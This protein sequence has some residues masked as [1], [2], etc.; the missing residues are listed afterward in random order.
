M[1]TVLSTVAVI[2][3]GMLV[4]RVV[5]REWTRINRSLDAHRSAPR[6]APDGHTQTLERDPETGVYR[7]SSD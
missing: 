6:A 4:W 2:L 3:G 7:P 1:S 5:K